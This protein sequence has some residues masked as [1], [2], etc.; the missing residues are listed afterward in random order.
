VVEDKEPDPDQGQV[1][2]TADLEVGA[3]VHDG[4]NPDGDDPDGDNPDGDNPDCVE[5]DTVAALELHRRR[6]HQPARRFHATS[7]MTRE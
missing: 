7:H 6:R 1:V 5:E 2:D 3:V 4:D